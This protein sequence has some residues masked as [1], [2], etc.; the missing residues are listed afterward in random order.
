MV[1]LGRRLELN[2]IYSNSWNTFSKSLLLFDLLKKEDFLIFVETEKKDLSYKKI[3]S[4]LW[5]RCF[6]MQNF[7]DFV[8]FF[9]NWNWK[10]LLNKD[11]FYI[12]FSVNFFEKNIFQIKKW[13][14]VDMLSFAKKLNDLGISFAEYEEKLHLNIKWEIF[15]YFTNS[16]NVLKISFWWDEVDEILLDNKKIDF[17]FFWLNK[18]LNSFSYVSE[19]NKFFVEKVKSTEKLIILDSIDFYNF[20]DEI[21][22]YLKNFISFANFWNW[23]EN[24]WVEEIFFNNL[25]EFKFKLE[26]KTSKKYI[27]TKNL[28]TI[29][30]FL[31]LNNLENISVFK[32]DLNNLKS[33]KIGLNYVFTDD[34]I[35]KIFVKRRVKRSFSENMDLLLQIKPGDYVVHIDHWVG[36]FSEI[37]T[38]EIPDQNGKTVKKEYITI[39]YKDNDKLFVPIMEVWRVSKYVWSEN[40]KLT[41]LWTK[42]WEKK[43]KKVSEDVEQIASE[44]LEI[45][46]KRNLQKWFAFESKKAEENEF[47]RSFE[48]VYTDDQHLAIEDIFTDMEKEIPMDRLLCWDVWFWKTEVAFAS[49]FK[50]LINDKQAVLISPLVVLA[51]EHF[52]KAKERF[53]DFPFNI[54]VLTRFEKPAVIKSTLQKL[55]EGKVDLVIW[56]HRLLS[57]DVKFKNLWL[58]VIDE[59]HKFWV[60]DKEKIKALKWNIDIL[61]MSATPIPRSLNMALNWLRQVSMLTT[62]PVWKQE[63]QT[64]ISDFN[65]WL[66]FDACKREFDRWWQV[67][68]IHNRVETILSLQSYLENILPGKKIL[69]TH[70]QLKWDTLEKRIIQF[71]RKEYD[72]LLS[73]TVIENGIDFANVNTIFI[74]DSVNFWISQIHQLRWRVWRWSQKWYCYLLFRKDQI[75]EDASKRLKTIVDY[76]HLWAWFELAI[77]DL[78]IRWWW[79]ILWIRQSWS[80]S[81]VWLNLFLEMLE[82]KIEEL[83]NAWLSESEEIKEKRIKTIVDLSIDAFIDD[84]LF[85]S[86]LDKINFYREIE[87]IRTLEELEIVKKDFFSFNENL[88]E[89]VKNFFDLLYLKIIWFAFKINSFRKVW[90]NYQIDFFEESNLDDLKKFLQ[91]DREVKFQFVDA[92]KLRSSVKNFENTEKFVEY[93]LKIFKW[94]NISTKKKIKLKK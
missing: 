76:S 1:D 61:S 15:T 25:D 13:D 70:W 46:A 37:V 88:S 80:S 52:E 8:D 22:W 42:D 7:C 72:L 5:E 64:I 29:K 23:L 79:D 90:I 41:N 44:L 73:T 21:I 86:E 78:E 75:K 24:L 31:E 17:Y 56:T 27:F 66:I 20:Y 54:E 59:E 53:K 89:S 9:L 63:I 45:Y 71:K 18:E 82:D 14:R 12:D 51:Y 77:K 19:V 3:L 92:K 65:D 83:K 10:F 93:L 26:E 68:F 57:S 94:E 36:I 38:K 34:I 30:N 43:L 39:D 69:V 55:Q 33:F 85:S 47:F 62:P 49:I 81:E 84:N 35:S 67:F 28:N 4:F 32:S 48:Y 60:K 6:L 2:R 16:W 74:N 87:N 50:C 40:P 91:L 58:L 11:I